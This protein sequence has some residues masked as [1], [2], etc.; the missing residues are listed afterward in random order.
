MSPAVVLL[1]LLAVSIPA[2]AHA[3]AYPAKPIRLILPFPPSGGTDTLG[4]GIAQTLSAQIVNRR[5]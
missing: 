4:R 3:Q 5:P 2:V 1:L